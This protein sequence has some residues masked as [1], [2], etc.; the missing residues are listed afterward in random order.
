MNELTREQ[1]CDKI[2]KLRNELAT[3]EDLLNKI[4]ADARAESEFTVK[5][6][7]MVGGYYYMENLSYADWY[8]RID[9]VTDIV[10]D[11]IDMYAKCECA[12][13]SISKSSSA[14]YKLSLEHIYIDR[15]NLGYYK[16]ITKEEFDKAIAK[17]NEKFNSPT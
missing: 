4:D 17:F 15:G 5:V 10:D 6:K 11:C 7:S 3:C 1:V 13:I 14:D 2:A 16:P 8:F 9:S 12:F